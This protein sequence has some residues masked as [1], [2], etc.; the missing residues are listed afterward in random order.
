MYGN[1]KCVELLK[2]KKKGFNV[3]SLGVC[4]PLNSTV[5]KGG[6]IASSYNTCNLIK[7]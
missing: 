1:I 7:V 5:S 3:F 6:T 2:K 4:K